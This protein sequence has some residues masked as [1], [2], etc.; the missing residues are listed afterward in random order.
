MI[1]PK[2]DIKDL[3]KYGA[4]TEF[5]NN[6]NEYF[7]IIEQ[8]QF[9]EVHINLLAGGMINPNML[10]GYMTAYMMIRDAMIRTECNELENLVNASH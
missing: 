2:I 5:V 9:P 7:G 10:I 6:L 8:E 1:M 4:S 3:L